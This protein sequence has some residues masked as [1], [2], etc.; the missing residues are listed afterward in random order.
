MGE[1]IAREA[2]GEDIETI[3]EI[4]KASY[5]DDYPYQY[6][7][8]AEWLKHSVYGDDMVMV[9]AE[10]EETGQILGTGS[11]VF[12]I[13]AHSDLIGEFGRLAVAPDARGRGVGKKIMEGRIRLIENRLHAGVVDN[14]TNHPYSQRISRDFGF[15]PV[16]FLP[17]KH[18]FQLRESIAMFAHHFGPALRLRRNHPHV[19]S[20]I[21]PIADIAMSNLGIEPDAIIDESTPAYPNDENFEISEFE[22]DGMPSLLRIERGRVKSREVFGP[23]RLHYGFFKLATREANYMVARRPGAPRESIAG[24][25]GYLHEEF[26]QNI[27]IFELIA[28]TDDSPRYLLSQ[29]L[30]RARENDVE[31]V[32]IEVSAHAPRMQRTLAEL[33]FLPAA[34]VPAMVFHEVERLDV[35]KMVRLLTEPVLGEIHLIDEMQPMVDAV[36]RAFETQAVLPQLESAIAGLGM[37]RG[38]SHEQARRLA[39]AMKVAHFDAETEIFATENGADELYVL[40]SG[41]VDVSL[42]GESLA[43]INAGDVVGENA[44]LSGCDHTASAR[45]KEPTTAAVLTREKLERLTQQ[46][47]DI[48]VVLYKN[49]AMSLGEKLRGA[50]QALRRK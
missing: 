20:Q 23:M 35:V 45:T 17:L 29:L 21:G 26:E 4:F 25:I 39:S 11:V 34:Y 40:L 16:G 19:I 9:V 6:F 2:R 5:G 33:G 10:D 31:Y 50:D 22:A 41:S 48:G 32:E 1:V 24:A 30:K 43:Q 47:P 28:A 38:L 27:R 13:G 46:R 37:F 12:D 44:M 15:V 8:D 42:G 36:M 14:R 3:R 18:K 7:Y 49:L